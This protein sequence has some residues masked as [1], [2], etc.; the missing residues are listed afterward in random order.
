MPQVL[1]CLCAQLDL[2]C[3]EYCVA[4]P[5]P[6]LPNIATSVSQQKDSLG[7]VMVARIPDK[8]SAV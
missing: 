7:Q 3:A 5:P 6:C 4:P 8:L 1:A 2:H